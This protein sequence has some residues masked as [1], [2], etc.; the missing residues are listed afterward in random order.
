MIEI[1]PNLEAVLLAGVAAGTGYIGHRVGAASAASDPLADVPV[2]PAEHVPA[3][4]GDAGQP[5][6]PPNPPAT[7]VAQSPPETPPAVP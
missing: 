7:A 5:Y 4:Q 2:T 3:D 1:G 6:A